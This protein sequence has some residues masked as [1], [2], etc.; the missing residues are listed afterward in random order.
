MVKYMQIYILHIF[1]HCE[2]LYTVRICRNC[3][4][5]DSLS[6]VGAERKTLPLLLEKW[7]ENLENA[8]YIHSCMRWVPRNTHWELSRRFLN[9]YGPTDPKLTL[10]IGY[11]C[12]QTVI[13]AYCRLGLF[14]PGP[15]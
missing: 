10:F 5:S 1:V 7:R 14:F 9:G 2:V 13:V 3:F 11:F 6:Q 8:R 15:D 4:V 12:F